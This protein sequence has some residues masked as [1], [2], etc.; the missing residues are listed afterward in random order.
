MG[1]QVSLSS[2]HRDIGIN[3]NFQQ[4]SSFVSFGSLALHEPL[5]VSRDVRPRV[6]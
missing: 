4:E 1:D 5:E 2:V 3:I 6:R